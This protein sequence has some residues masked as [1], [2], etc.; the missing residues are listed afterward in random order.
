VIQD[1]ETSLF[2]RLMLYAMRH[3]GWSYNIDVFDENAVTNDPKDRH[4]LATA[5]K[6]GATVIV[7]YNERTSHPPRPR[8]GESRSKAQALS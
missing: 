4:V 2:M 8:P 3:E 6:S 5:V 7:T 1:L